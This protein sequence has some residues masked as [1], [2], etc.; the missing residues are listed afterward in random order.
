MNASELASKMLEAEKLH[1]Q[2]VGIEKEIEQAVL[3]LKDS[4]KVGNVK[5]AY[6]NGRR[7]LDWQPS[8]LSAPQEV[9]E[10]Y[11]KTSEWVDYEQAC[12][13]AKVSEDILIECTHY[14]KT[15][16]YAA[17][18]KELKLEPVVVKEGV[19]SVKISY[20]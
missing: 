12:E 9:I 18:C 16:D 10:K 15:T 13:I 6:T 20:S 2:L 5:A 17:I 8:A 11:T 3:E 1:N 7:E 19:P 4:Q 14:D